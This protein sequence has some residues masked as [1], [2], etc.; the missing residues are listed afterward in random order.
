MPLTPMHLSRVW[1]HRRGFYRNRMKRDITGVVTDRM[2][3]RLAK[4][5]TRMGQTIP[6]GPAGVGMSNQE[7]RK[8]LQEVDPVVKRDLIARAGD[9]E[10][11]KVMQDLYGGP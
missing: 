7:V 1:A 3:T 6:Y 2:R 10:W 5:R 4:F 9:D 11:R 8:R